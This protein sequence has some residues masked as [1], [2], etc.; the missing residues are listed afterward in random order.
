MFKIFPQLFFQLV[1]LII[2]IVQHFITIF[3]LIV[4]FVLWIIRP[5]YNM[6]CI[7]T[8]KNLLLIYL[9]SYNF[10]FSRQRQEIEL[11]LKEL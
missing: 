9:Q 11:Y 8:L 5:F 4:R 7:F 2:K 1:D 3:F 10:Y 6:H